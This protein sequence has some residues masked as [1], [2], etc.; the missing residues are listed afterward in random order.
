MELT[1]DR[2]EK[3]SYWSG[4][5][6]LG[7]RVSEEVLSKQIAVCLVAVVDITADNCLVSF[8]HCKVGGCTNIDP[9]AG[10]LM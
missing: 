7:T 3:M 6:H 5:E 10:A 8:Q 4:W 9:S 2:E 1:S